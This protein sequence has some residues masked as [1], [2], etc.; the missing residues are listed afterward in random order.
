M[1]YET[2]GLL[3]M[4]FPPPQ[5]LLASLSTPD[6]PLMRTLLNGNIRRVVI[7]SLTH[8][9]RMTADTHELRATYNTIVNALRRE[10]V[11]ALLLAEETRSDFK[12]DEKGRLSFIVDCILLLRYLEINSAIQRAIVVLKFRSSDHDKGIHPYNIG[13]G[14]I[15]VV[16]PFQDHVGLVRDPSRPACLPPVPTGPP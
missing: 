15:T 12:N 16:P 7:D 8:F 10:G 1:D 14:G 6:S 4:I 5:V 3:K 2:N 11:T 9:T 13:P